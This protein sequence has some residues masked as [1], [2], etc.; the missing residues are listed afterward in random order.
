MLRNPID[1][2][3]ERIQGT[4]SIFVTAKLLKDRR[5]V[6]GN[7][8]AVND[9]RVRLPIIRKNPVTQCFRETSHHTATRKNIQKRRLLGF[10]CLGQGPRNQIKEFSLV[11]NIRNELV[12]DEIFRPYCRMPLSYVC[13]S[14][15][16]VKS[17]TSCSE[18][19]RPS[20]MIIFRT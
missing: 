16:Q 19:W 6:V 15:E 12:K 18:A 14:I 5:L 17:R 8:T 11:P 20:A 10:T 2:R 3:R 1:S 9:L 13:R 7:V 4:E